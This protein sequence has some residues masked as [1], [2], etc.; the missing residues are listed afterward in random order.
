MNT[1][2]LIPAVL[3]LGMAAGSTA[4]YAQTLNT[5]TDLGTSVEA[6]ENGLGADATLGTN[7]DATT[8]TPPA[9]TIPPADANTTADIQTT[10]DA[11]ALAATD[12]LVGVRVYDQNEEWIGEVSAILPAQASGEA[13]LVVDVGGFLGIGEKPIAI[14]ASEAQVRMNDGGDVD[15][16]VV[17][18]TQ[19]ELE[20][21]P[22]VEM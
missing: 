11:T 19:A 3:A 20:A 21:M 9:A 5:D 10:V 12:E 6:G 2:H 14:D 15:F 8:S 4:A 22:E 13:Q 16:L 1:K 18:Y 17:A 7:A